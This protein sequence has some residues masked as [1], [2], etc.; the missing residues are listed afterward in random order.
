MK[1]V[2]SDTGKNYN[3]FFEIL[4]AADVKL[5]LKNTGHMKCGFYQGKV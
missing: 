5:I 1:P 2:V 4:V 3:H